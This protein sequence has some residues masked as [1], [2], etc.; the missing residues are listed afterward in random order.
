MLL[1]LAALAGWALV[2][3][4]CKVLVVFA[5]F[6]F[7]FCFFIC[8]LLFGHYYYYYR[9]KGGKAGWR[10]GRRAGQ[11]GVMYVFTMRVVGEGW[12][13]EAIFLFSSVMV[14]WLVVGDW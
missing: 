3:K 12:V 9:P 2:R 6:A 1:S 14:F 5:N 11:T 7:G 10:A 4:E 8:L 13:I